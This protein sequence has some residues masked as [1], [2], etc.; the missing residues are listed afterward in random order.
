MN[1]RVIAN[2]STPRTHDSLVAD[3]RALGV[4]RSLILLVHSSLSA[5]GWVCGGEVTVISALLEVLG[6]DGTLVMPSHS[7]QLT[8]PAKWKSPPVPPSWIDIIRSEM[9]VFDPA[10]TPTSGIGKIPELFRTWPGV[11]R[12]LHPAYSF[13]AIGPSA[14]HILRDHRLDCALDDSS[15][16]GRLYDLKATIL[17]LGVGFERC[18]ALHLA[19]SRVFPK[20]EQDAGPIVADGVR[21]WAGYA[22]PSFNADC[23]PRIGES[24]IAIGIAK[25]G[26]VGS[27]N[28]FLLPIA[29]SVDFATQ[30]LRKNVA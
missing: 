5:L 20:S 11:K 26:R 29:A 23:F 15:P 24:L 9:P 8:D 25:T 21:R 18:T 16:L 12:S 17:M 4:Q 10:R 13:A 1:E 7:T 14:E 3:L 27:A 6:P 22:V 19:E 28:C 30:W 2:T